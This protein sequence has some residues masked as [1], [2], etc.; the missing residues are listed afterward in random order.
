MRH[1]GVMAVSEKG[2]QSKCHL[3]WSGFGCWRR[4]KRAKIPVVTVLEKL[5]TPLPSSDKGGDGSWDW[6]RSVLGSQQGVDPSAG[7]RTHTCAAEAAR[8]PSG[9]DFLRVP[10]TPAFNAWEASETSFHLFQETEEAARN[11]GTYDT[12]GPKACWPSPRYLQPSS[13][14]NSTWTWVHY[15]SDPAHVLSAPI[16]GKRPQQECSLR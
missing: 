4:P 13:A 7:V 10:A 14:G 6:G 15:R 9:R 11:R 5:Q 8:V 16:G 1:V 3:D 12:E 2:D